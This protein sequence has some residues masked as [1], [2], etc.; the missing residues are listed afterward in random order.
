MSKCCNTMQMS[1]TIMSIVYNI[2]ISFNSHSST[3]SDI[4][5][6]R[7]LHESIPQPKQNNAIDW[8]I[9]PMLIMHSATCTMYNHF[10]VEICSLVPNLH[11]QLFFACCVKKSWEWRLGTRL[12]RCVHFLSCRKMCTFPL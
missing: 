2:I 4:W 6:T 7:L 1:M 5:P 12:E 11:S 10:F 8:Y 3:F 9:C